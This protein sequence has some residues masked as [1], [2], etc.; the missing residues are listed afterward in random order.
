MCFSTVRLKMSC[1]QAETLSKKEK[2]LFLNKA[3]LDWPATVIWVL[4]SFIFASNLISNVI[5]DGTL[6]VHIS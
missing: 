2:Q 6:H 1:I 5:G 4:S 3:V